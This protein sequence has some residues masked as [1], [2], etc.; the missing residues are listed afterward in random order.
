MQQGSVREK[1]A[2][3]PAT[4]LATVENS[5]ASSHDLMLIDAG[6]GFLAVPSVEGKLRQRLSSSTDSPR[7]PAR[8]PQEVPSKR[9]Q[10]NTGH[11]GE[12][13]KGTSHTFLRRQCLHRTAAR[14]GPIFF[15]KDVKHH[16][17]PF[18]LEVYGPNPG[19]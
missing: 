6:T 1:R 10:W 13:R 7:V 11:S 12:R 5:L 2:W 3:Q 14:I 19:Q 17:F 16:E 8:G 4:H 9:E 15:L 18:L